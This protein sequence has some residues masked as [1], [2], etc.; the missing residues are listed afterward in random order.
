MIRAFDRRASHK[1][2]RA[3]ILLSAFVATAVML[4]LVY[5]AAVAPR[6][7]PLLPY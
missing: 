3:T 6:G 7:V 1:P 2:A 5:L 4:A